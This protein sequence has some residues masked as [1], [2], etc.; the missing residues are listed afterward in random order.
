VSGNTV[1]GPRTAFLVSNS[2]PIELDN[3][4]VTGA[5]VF[6]IS[7]RGESSKVKGVGNVISGTGFRAVDARADASA[8]AL[9]ATNSSGWAYHGK[10]SFWSY[11]R[12]H[13]LA[14]LWLGISILVLFA[15]L[16]SRRRRLPSHPYPAS[17][18]WSRNAP[19]AE[20]APATAGLA[21]A[22]AA[23]PAPAGLSAAAPVPAMAG[24]AATG[25]APGRSRR[26]AST[27]PFRA[28]TGALR[29]DGALVG[30][31]GQRHREQT[32]SGSRVSASHAYGFQPG[33]QEQPRDRDSWSSV[34]GQ[35]PAA[36]QPSGRHGRPDPAPAWPADSEPPARSSDNGRSAWSSSAWPGDSDPAGTRPEPMIG[37]K[38]VRG[39]SGSS[40]TTAAADRDNYF[41]SFSARPKEVDTP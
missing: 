21:P 26:V 10:V 6:G 11:L 37:G 31:R 18:R 14:A 27:V 15:W 20:S 12:F 2:G 25:G 28:I 32:T 19:A 29:P 5:T 39:S 13:P 22:R 24:V 23:P 30:G 41:D 9:S 4:R 33:A 17:T 1:A 8:P 36:Y 7:A 34:G 38:A 35:E 16:W 3:N 40:P